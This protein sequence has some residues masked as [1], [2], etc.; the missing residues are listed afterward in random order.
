[1]RPSRT[2]P[3]V[4]NFFRPIKI[5]ATDG[6]ELGIAE[7]SP[8]CQALQ[9]IQTSWTFITFCGP[10]I[11]FTVRLQENF[12][13]ARHSRLLPTY[14]CSL[15][16]KHISCGCHVFREQTNNGQRWEKSDHFSTSFVAYFLVICGNNH[17]ACQ[18]LN[19]FAAACTCS[20][21]KTFKTFYPFCDT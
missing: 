18:T 19:V 9:S 1:M 7:C 6:K 3:R 21:V 15:T 17:I 20:T 14:D 5:I 12:F 13:K 16:V 2:S 4:N 11:C 8:L 10:K